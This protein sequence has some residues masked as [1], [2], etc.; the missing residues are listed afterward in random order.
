MRP[1]RS[2]GR[3]AGA[4][5]WRSV[6][7][8][9]TRNRVPRR[10]IPR[11]APDSSAEDLIPPWIC[12]PHMLRILYLHN[13]FITLSTSSRAAI[14]GYPMAINLFIGAARERRV[15]GEGQRRADAAKYCKINYQLA[16]GLLPAN[17]TRDY[18]SSRSSLPAPE[19][20]F[21]P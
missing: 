17:A 16:A 14:R 9:F 13:L 7:S 6:I 10:E 20:S 1:A 2:W 3:A 4:S 8:D 19:I 12:P 5:D 18:A 11:A 21:P 15:G